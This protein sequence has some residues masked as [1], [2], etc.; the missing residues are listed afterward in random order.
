MG[1]KQP[2][3]LPQAKSPVSVYIVEI[4]GS[5]CDCWTVLTGSQVSQD[6]MWRRTGTLSK[7]EKRCKTPSSVELKEAKEMCY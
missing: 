4:Q 2:L 3:A 7:Y 6:F 5:S 1:G